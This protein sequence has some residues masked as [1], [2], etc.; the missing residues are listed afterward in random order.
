MAF[1]YCYTNKING[2]SYVG[3]T[4]DID[5]RKYQHEWDAFIRKSNTYFHKALRK[6]GLNAFEF[7]VLEE[8]TGNDLNVMNE[9]EIYWISKIGSFKP[10]GYNLTIGGGGSNGFKASQET[11]KLLSK[12]NKAKGK[13]ATKEANKAYRK[14]LQ[15]PEFREKQRERLLK[16]TK[17]LG[18]SKKGT[19]KPKN[20][21]ATCT[22]CGK[23]YMVAATHTSVS[24]NK[25]CTK[26]CQSRWR[27]ASGLDNED[28]I[29]V[30]CGKTFSVN[31]YDKTKCCSR[32]C[33][34]KL[35]LKNGGTAVFR[36]K[37]C[38]TEY[39]GYT[40]VKNKFCSERCRSAD[41]RRRYKNKE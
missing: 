16:L 39:E 14:K 36:C 17:E 20:I 35:K 5:K 21:Q 7:S 38:G 23:E 8:I 30:I 3:Q 15:D 40:L 28:R 29:C 22:Y 1:I 24:D 37:E 18:M 19:T 12:I 33:G 25:F 31:K 41:K 13:D 11:R 32:S 34:A 6:Y 2:K 4:I 9:R 26:V 27:R 10:N